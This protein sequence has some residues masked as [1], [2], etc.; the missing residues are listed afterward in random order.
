MQITTYKFGSGVGS[1]TA[2]GA[3]GGGTWTFNTSRVGPLPAAG[4][5]SVQIYLRF[6]DKN[7]NI[8]GKD[9]PGPIATG[10]IVGP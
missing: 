8:I 10:V 1:V 5:Y 7:G 2:P 4:T 3:G 6:F 9:I